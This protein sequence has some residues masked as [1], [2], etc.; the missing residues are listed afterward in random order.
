MMRFFAFVD[1]AANAPQP[2]RIVQ[3]KGAAAGGARAAGLGNKPKLGTLMLLPN[4]RPSGRVCSSAFRA[5]V[6]V[7]LAAQTRRSWRGR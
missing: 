5:R 4:E 3:T 6:R 1:Y 2:A 7:G